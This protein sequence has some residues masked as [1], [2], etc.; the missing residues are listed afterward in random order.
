MLYKPVKAGKLQLRYR[1]GWKSFFVRGGEKPLLV[2][3]HQERQM[4]RPQPTKTKAPLRP[5]LYHTRAEG[6]TTKKGGHHGHDTEKGERVS[7]HGIRRV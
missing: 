3:Q 1:H 4:Q 2:F 7:H 5:L 6:A